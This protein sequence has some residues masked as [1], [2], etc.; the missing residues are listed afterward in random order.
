MLA[1]LACVGGVHDRGEGE[2]AYVP[3]QQ[4]YAPL[5]QVYAPHSLLY[6]P[7]TQAY[8]PLNQLYAPAATPTIQRGSNVAA[9]VDKVSPD[10][11]CPRSTRR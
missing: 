7:L 8:A 5:Q 3:L 9:T 4:A 1:F 11:P 6:A 2:G 10:L